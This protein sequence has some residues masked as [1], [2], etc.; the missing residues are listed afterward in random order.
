[1]GSEPTGAAAHGQGVAL[2]SPY[3]YCRGVSDTVAELLSRVER[4]ASVA[5]DQHHRAGELTANR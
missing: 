3:P 1:V 4:L 5:I 2:H